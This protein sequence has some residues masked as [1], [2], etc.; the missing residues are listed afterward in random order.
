VAEVGKRYLMQIAG[1]NLGTILRKLIGVGTPREL[2]T[3]SAAFL[4]LF[5]A[6]VATILRT[7]RRGA[8]PFLPT[9]GFAF[10]NRDLAGHAPV[11]SGAA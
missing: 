9:S 5:W 3:R 10:E 6:C 8:A 2:A 7:A 11:A 1:L 4:A